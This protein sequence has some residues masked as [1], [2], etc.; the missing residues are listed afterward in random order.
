MNDIK[1]VST[2]G[3]IDEA[4]KC[5]RKIN[6]TVSGIIHTEIH[7][8]PD[9]EH[10]DTDTSLWN[11]TNLHMPLSAIAMTSEDMT[12]IP[13]I[14]T[15]MTNTDFDH[16]YDNRP[17][18]LIVTTDRRFVKDIESCMINQGGYDIHCI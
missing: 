2:F 5:M 13:F 1:V 17:C 3:S 9:N 4:E 6:D 11:I 7:S 8:K 18:D 15:E 10:S 16:S 14:S 12:A